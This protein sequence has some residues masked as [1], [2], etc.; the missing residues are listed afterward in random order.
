[1]KTNRKRRKLLRYAV[2]IIDNLS[3]GFLW[4]MALTMLAY[5]ILREVTK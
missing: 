1:M 5:A 4:A 2:L 3:I